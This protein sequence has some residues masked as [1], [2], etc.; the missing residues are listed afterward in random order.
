MSQSMRGTEM[1]SFWS[2]ALR[3]KSFVLGGVLT[4]LLAAPGARAARR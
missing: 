2:R 1:D 3:H 4:L